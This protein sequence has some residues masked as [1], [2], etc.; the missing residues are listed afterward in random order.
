MCTC[1]CTCV[2]CRCM[3]VREC[4]YSWVCVCVLTRLNVC[5]QCL[6]VCSVPPKS[7]LLAAVGSQMSRNHVSQPP[8]QA[9][10]HSQ[11]QPRHCS[12]VPPQVLIQDSWRRCPP[13]HLLVTS[14]HFLALNPIFFAASHTLFWSRLPWS[15]KPLTSTS[16]VTGRHFLALVPNSSLS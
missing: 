15:G 6:C 7:P 11:H 2:L 3:Y 8:S 12:S 4:V 13:A 14:R 9:I 16:L 5:M 10:H 1:V